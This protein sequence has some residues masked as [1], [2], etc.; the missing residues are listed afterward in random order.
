MG[1][2]L[3]PLTGCQKKCQTHT[4][5]KTTVACC[6]AEMQF[7]CMQVSVGV[8]VVVYAVGLNNNATLQN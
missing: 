3:Q 8:V 6:S 1:S 5:K 2:C 7:R 4:P